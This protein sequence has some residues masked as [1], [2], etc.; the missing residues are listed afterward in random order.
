VFCESVG[1]ELG[2][3]A[4]IAQDDHAGA[5]GHQVAQVRR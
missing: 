4:A 2:A 1:A 5:H 3:D